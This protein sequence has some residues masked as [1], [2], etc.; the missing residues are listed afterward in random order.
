M[1]MSNEKLDELLNSDL[2]FD[3][4][5]NRIFNSYY[6]NVEFDGVSAWN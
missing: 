3:E 4:M 1:N 2:S 5:L 6:R